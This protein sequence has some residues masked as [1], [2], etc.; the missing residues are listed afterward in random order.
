MDRDKIFLLLA[1]LAVTPTAVAINFQVNIDAVADAGVYESRYTKETSGIQ[2]FNVSV[3]NIASAGCTYYLRGRYKEGN[4]TVERYSHGYALWPG[5]S[6]LMELKH[7]PINYTGAVKADI[8]MIYCGVERNVSSFKFNM[9]ER[10]IVDSKIESETV[11][12]DGDR[13]KIM[14]PVSEGELIPHEVPAYW[15]VGSTQ[16]SD[17]IATIRYDPTIFR[18]DKEI[19]YTVLDSDGDIIGDTTV[20]LDVPEPTLL[21]R[22][23]AKSGLILAVFLLLSLGLNLYQG[24]RRVVP[25][26]VRRLVSKVAEAVRSELSDFGDRDIRRN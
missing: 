14:L 3:E 25:E 17:G 8:D 24:R 19:T 7:L 12:V 1:V 23:K 10:K 20:K 13:A 9:T 26:K 21:E 6:T 4:R 15:K 2:N 5:N 22:L 16:V 18:S 11:E